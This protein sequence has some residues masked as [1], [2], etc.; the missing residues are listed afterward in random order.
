M[1]IVETIISIFVVLVGL[2]FMLL[3][4]QMSQSREVG[5]LTRNTCEYNDPSVTLA[6]VSSLWTSEV[7]TT[8]IWEA[9]TSL[10][11]GYQKRRTMEQQNDTLL[12]LFNRFLALTLFFLHSTTYTAHPPPCYWSVGFKLQLVEY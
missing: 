6:D 11:T 4:L 2:Q 9:A 12:P 7:F 1:D 8:S 10:H 3:G 5:C